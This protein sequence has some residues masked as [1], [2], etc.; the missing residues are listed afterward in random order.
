[1]AMAIRG[2][3]RFQIQNYLPS[4][5]RP[6]GNTPEPLGEGIP[7]DLMRM[8]SGGKNNFNRWNRGRGV[9]TEWRRIQQAQ[10]MKVMAHNKGEEPAKN[11]YNLGRLV[12]P[13][14]SLIAHRM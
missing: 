4:I 1:M 6:A 2:K 3:A 14:Q 12:D 7:N 10:T 9:H 13:I 11:R 8:P 5:R